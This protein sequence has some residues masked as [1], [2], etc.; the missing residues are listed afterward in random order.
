MSREVDIKLDMIRVYFKHRIADCLSEDS[1]DDKLGMHIFQLHCKGDP[2][3]FHVSRAFIDAHSPAEILTTLM[4]LHPESYIRG[5]NTG[6]VSITMD[7]VKVE[8]NEI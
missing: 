2:T 7:G 3:R 6:H 5:I 1:Y 4:R 8:S